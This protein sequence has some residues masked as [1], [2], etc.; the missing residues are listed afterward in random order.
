MESLRSASVGALDTLNLTDDTLLK[1]R[2][3][4]NRAAFASHKSVLVK[5]KGVLALELLN[6][7]PSEAEES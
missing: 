3:S 1:R 7:I 4:P 2:R 6:V 5:R